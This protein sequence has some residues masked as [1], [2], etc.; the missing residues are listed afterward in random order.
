MS[1]REIDLTMFNEDMT[2]ERAKMVVRVKARREQKRRTV[3]LRN[4]RAVKYAWQG[5]A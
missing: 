1:N 5:R 2:A 4:A 3:V